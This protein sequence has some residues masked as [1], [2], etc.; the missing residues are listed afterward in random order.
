MKKR[1]IF[2][3]ATFPRR[4][5]SEIVGSSEAI[6]RATAQVLRVASSNSTVLITGESGAGKELIARAI[7]KRSRRSRSDWN[8]NVHTNSNQRPRPEAL[9]SKNVCP[10]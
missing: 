10:I 7:H 1:S 5:Y 3:T 8:R 4:P 9:H 6:C 2:S